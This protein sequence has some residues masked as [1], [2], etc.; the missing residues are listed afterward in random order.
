MDFIHRLI[1][2]ERI[3]EAARHPLSV[4]RARAATATEADRSAIDRPRDTQAA[5]EVAGEITVRAGSLRHR[6]TIQRPTNSRSGS[7]A[8]LDQYEDYLPDIS[9]AVEVITGR[10]QWLANVQ[11]A[12]ELS[13]RIRIRYRDG[14]TAQ[15]RVLHIVRG[16]SPTRATIYDIAAV[17]SADTRQRE[18]Y[19]LCTTRDAE[20]FRRGES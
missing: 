6:V 4:V 13:A 1:P 11:V 18:L 14:L 19:L 3:H 12:A 8:I 5:K 2:C 16:G 9:A 17:I 7:G 10:E 15:M 20:G